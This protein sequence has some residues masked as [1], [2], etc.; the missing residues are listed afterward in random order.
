MNRLLVPRP[1]ERP[2]FQLHPSCVKRLIARRGLRVNH[3]GH[4]RIWTNGQVI[5]SG[6]H[7]SGHS[8]PYKRRPI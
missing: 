1:D 5:R 2:S 7:S 4:P 8:S 6:D 3:C